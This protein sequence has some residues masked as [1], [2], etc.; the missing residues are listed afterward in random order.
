MTDPATN[1]ILLTH[2]SSSVL[3][4]GGLQWLKQ[5]KWV[6][7]ATKLI[8]RTFSVLAAVA[9]HIGIQWTWNPTNHSLLISGLSLG[10]IAI[11]LYHIAAQYI[12]QETG[13][14]VLQGI[15]S[16]QGILSVLQKEAPKP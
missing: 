15:Q 7:Q 14:Q 2:L 1:N 12:Y 5:A 10:A 9:I 3:V 6:Q 16:A 4:V 11:A 13:Y 8:C